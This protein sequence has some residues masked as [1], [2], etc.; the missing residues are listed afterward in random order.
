MFWNER[1]GEFAQE[2]KVNVE[3]PLPVAVLPLKIT[4]QDGG[5]GASE[6]V[7]RDLVLPS[8]NAALQNALFGVLLDRFAFCT[9]CLHQLY[10]NPSLAI[11]TLRNFFLLELVSCGHVRSIHKQVHE[12]R[13]VS[14]TLATRQE[15][16]APRP[17]VVML[18][19]PLSNQK[20]LRQASLMFP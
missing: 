3:L 12:P 10:R 6:A 9:T 19:L 11:V 17:L 1:L 16:S 14:C 5:G 7:Q 4:A 2:V 13:F 8:K 15:R 18:S 20:S